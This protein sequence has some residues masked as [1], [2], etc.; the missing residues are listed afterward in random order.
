MLM[1][2]GR[3][4]FGQL[5]RSEKQECIQIGTGGTAGHDALLGRGTLFSSLKPSSRKDNGQI[6]TA[7]RTVEEPR[8]EEAISAKLSEPFAW[9]NC[10]LPLD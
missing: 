7:P 8:T 5:T 4:A 3:L 1:E 9:R 6:K 10:F 2:G